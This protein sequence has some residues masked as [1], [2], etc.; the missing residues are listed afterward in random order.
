MKAGITEPN[1]LQA[2]IKKIMIENSIQT[3]LLINHSKFGMIALN[4]V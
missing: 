4:K 1:P 2:F 3:I